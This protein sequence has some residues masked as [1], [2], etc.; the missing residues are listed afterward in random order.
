M[1]NLSIII[2]VFNE[3]NNLIKLTKLIKSE[4]RLKNYEV[5][6]VD[7]DSNDG[8]K[9][10]LRQIKKKNNK[11]SFILRK[12]KP[13]DLSKSCFLGFSKSK[14]D[15]ILV[16]D[17]DLQHDPKDIKKLIKAYKKYKPEI[18]VGSRNLFNLENRSLGFVRLFA[19]K[20]LILIVRF[21]L[22]SR[23]TDPMSG[24]FLFKK[25]LLKKKKKFHRI[26]YKILLDLIYPINYNIKI[27][28]VD[29]NFKTRKIGYSKMNLKVLVI[30]IYVILAKFFRL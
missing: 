2:P 7:D 8:S 17:G 26:G 25:N 15:N 20:L 10:V 6:F 29:I 23:T 5:I 11:F 21:L 14:F 3:R 12:E 19:S 30:L 18:V 13:R 9:K 4:L 24:F 1:K 22:G 28:D 16:M 27:I